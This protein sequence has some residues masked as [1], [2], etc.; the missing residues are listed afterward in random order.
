[1]AHWPGARAKPSALLV[2]MVLLAGCGGVTTAVSPL[3]RSSSTGALAPT[4]ITVATASPTPTTNLTTAPS[5]DCNSRSG[6]TVIPRFTGGDEGAWTASLKIPCGWTYIPAYRGQ[7]VC[8][9]GDCYPGYSDQLRGPQHSSIS[10]GAPTAMSPGDTC[11]SY[12]ERNEGDEPWYTLS[13]RQPIN[14]SGIASTEYTFT[15]DASDGAWVTYVVPLTSDLLGCVVLDYG[16]AEGAVA[17]AT[18]D[19]I[20]TSITFHSSN[21]G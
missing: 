17:H 2:A 3:A 20:F 18:V 9:N 12:A 15:R 4:P 13:G 19:L 10:I 21:R 14:V 1:M 8:P 7:G 6:W 11:T 5:P 16:A